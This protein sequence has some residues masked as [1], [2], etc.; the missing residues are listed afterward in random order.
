MR[1][2]AYFAKPWIRMALMALGVVLLLALAIGGTFAWHF[3]PWVKDADFPKPANTTEAYEQD[4]RYLASY[5]RYEKAFQDA[6]KRAAFD[7]HLAQTRSQLRDMT[8]ARFELAVARAVAFADNGHT[9]VSP[10]GRSRRVNRF[11][12]RTGPFEDG[13]FVVQARREHAD[14][15]G[16]EVLAVEEHPIGKV[17]AAFVPYF[18]GVE[19]RSRFFMHVTLSSPALL[20]AMGF[21]RSA[22]SATLTLRL[23]SGEIVKRELA[24][25][26]PAS[27][28]RQPFGREVMDYRVPAAEEPD[29]VHLMAGQAAPPYLT[30]PDEPYLYRVLEPQQGAYIKINFNADVDD[31]SLVDWLDE[32]MADMA[33]RRPAFAVV[34]LRFNGGGTDATADLA[35]RLPSLVQAGGPI[36]VL[37]SRETF[38]AAIGATAQIKQ[39]A[40]RRARVVGGPVGD[41][42]RFVANGGTP[43]TLPNSKIV[44][45]VWSAWEDYADGCWDWTECFWLSPFFRERGV[46]HLDPDLPVA[47]NFRDYVQNRDA[48]LEAVLAAQ[49][50]AR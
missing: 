8:P 45:A 27:G 34:D 47:L 31:R 37:T 16:A 26:A 14:L 32:V 20:H 46:G 17:T 39:F 23:R 21:T 13:E 2:R 25:S 11:P 3:I 15:L 41:R 33:S 22:D 1:I 36:Y 42:L 7:R 48:A 30:L 10:L 9:N 24:G 19:R 50:A 4:L 29:W 18:G 12:V 35:R 5:A 44:I 40:G 28:R 43:F 38:S 6:A 49:A